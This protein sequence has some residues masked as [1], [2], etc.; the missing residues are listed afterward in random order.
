MVDEWPQREVSRSLANVCGRSDQA[1]SWPLTQRSSLGGCDLRSRVVSAEPALFLS[2]GVTPLTARRR[3]CG[4][5][6]RAPGPGTEWPAAHGPRRL[7]CHGR[8][9]STHRNVLQR[10]VASPALCL[11]ACEAVGEDG[12]SMN[13]FA[14]VARG[15]RRRGCACVVIDRR[16]APDLRPAAMSRAAPGVE[17]LLGAV[18]VS[19]PVVPLLGLRR[20]RRSA[21]GRSRGSGSR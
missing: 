20:S 4:R 1:T 10:L 13:A 5:C 21:P 11:G 7:P 19:A 3:Q 18:I 14:H 15:T 2:Q 16:H 12:P 17:R 8:G 9:P 6:R